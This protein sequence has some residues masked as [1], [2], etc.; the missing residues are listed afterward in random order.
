MLQKAINRVGTWKCRRH[1]LDKHPKHRLSGPD[2]AIT[3]YLDS[4]HHEN[5]NLAPSSGEKYFFKIL[6]F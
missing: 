1:W 4:H 3:P 6:N 2:M 5:F